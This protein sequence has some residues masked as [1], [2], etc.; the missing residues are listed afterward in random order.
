M[1][2]FRS[3]QAV[4]KSLLT[5]GIGL[6][7]AAIV[8]GG[9]NVV[10]FTVPLVPSVPRQ[11]LLAVLGIGVAGL[12]LWVKPT[13]APDK[14]TEG[15][16]RPTQGPEK[17]AEHK[18]AGVT[19]TRS[20]GLVAAMPSEVVLNRPT[21]VW[22]QV[23]LPR[24]PGFVE[25]LPQYTSSGEEIAQANARRFPGSVQFRE[26]EGRLMNALLS[27][28]V[29]SQ[30]FRVVNEKQSLSL[31]PR[32]D[33]G[34]LVFEAVPTRVVPR[35]RVLVSVTQQQD[36]VSVTVAIASVM[37][38]VK[39]TGDGLEALVPWN[40]TR[41]GEVSDEREAGLSG[42]AALP[43]A[44]SA[45]DP[46]EGPEEPSSSPTIYE[47]Q[48]EQPAGRDVVISHNHPV[49]SI[50][51]PPP[52]AQILRPWLVLTAVSIFAVAVF[53]IWRFLS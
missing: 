25:S 9:L 33:S 21:E 23:C 12:S 20:R 11:I 26:R 4:E 30:D 53:V 36:A 29:T 15:P 8:G 19:R 52:K 16:E 39:P 1:Q 44:E 50:P 42:V 45:A 40:V 46:A 27:V 13:E 24:S 32:H 51:S 47:D 2:V 10:G 43:E 48:R 17:P 35:A 49:S 28:V 38:R 41:Q 6:V 31:S 14:P 34:V 37:A 22:V 7:L 3:R 18:P 5:L